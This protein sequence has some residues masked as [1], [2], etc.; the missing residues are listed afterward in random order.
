MANSKMESFSDFGPCKDLVLYRKLLLK[1][2]IIKYIVI[3]YMLY[4]R[5]HLYVN[6]NKN[7]IY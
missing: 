2:L 7:A 4:W 3:A 5:F 6:G 1:K